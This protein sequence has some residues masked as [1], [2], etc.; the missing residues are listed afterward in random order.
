MEYVTGNTLWV[1]A[2]DA[3]GYERYDGLY[4]VASYLVEMGVRE[5]LKKCR[6][7]GFA[8]RGFDEYNY[9]SLY[10]GDDREADPVKSLTR[11][12]LAELNRDIKNLVADLEE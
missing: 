10:W 1:R 2:G 7:Y 8:T 5:P 3:D 4:E 12:E 11:A 6:P 9:I